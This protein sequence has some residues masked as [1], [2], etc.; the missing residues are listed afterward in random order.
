MRQCDVQWV[1]NLWDW[2][3]SFLSPSHSPKTETK[4]RS[5]QRTYVHSLSLWSAVGITVPVIQ[6][7]QAGSILSIVRQQMSVYL[8]CTIEPY[9][10]AHWPL[11][12]WLLHLLQEGSCTIEPYKLAHWPLTGWLLHLLQE[13][14]DWVRCHTSATYNSPSFKGQCYSN[15]TTVTNSFCPLSSPV[16]ETPLM[17]VSRT[18]LSWNLS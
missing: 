15:Y 16:R 12:G 18:G 1:A 8:S 9:K 14:G 6:W 5:L 3:T 4:E 11:T 17:F 2:K 10:L 13:G 7:I